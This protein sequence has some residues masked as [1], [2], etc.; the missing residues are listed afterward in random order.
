[1]LSMEEIRAQ[2][3]NAYRVWTKEDDARLVTLYKSGKSIKELTLIFQR[4]DGAITSRLR[5]LSV[6]A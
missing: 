2:Y 5:K 4:N 1:M 3:P 6:I